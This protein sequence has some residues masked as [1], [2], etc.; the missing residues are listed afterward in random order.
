MPHKFLLTLS[1]MMFSLLGCST[2]NTEII[3]LA[4]QTNS[5]GQLENAAPSRERQGTEQPMIEPKAGRLL[6]QMTDL[7]SSTNAFTFNALTIKEQV[8]PSGQK[9]QYDAAIQVKMQRPNALLVNITSGAKKKTLWYQ[10]TT[11]SL[12]DRNNNFYATVQVPNNI[13]DTLDFIMDHYG[14]SMPLADF[15]VADPYHDVTENNLSGFY[16]AEVE[17]GGKKTHHLAF[18]QAD[19]DWQIWIDA[20]GRPIPRKFV[21]TYKDKASVPEFIAFFKD[22]N[23]SPQFKSNEFTFQPSKNAVKIDFYSEQKR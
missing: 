20:D 13:D 3:E 2:T 22:W 15:V 18:R 9:L 19:V 6:K 8:L 17:V 5:V 11:F 7:L 4:P 21:I 23:L 14:V 16:V 12:L 10:H 1:I